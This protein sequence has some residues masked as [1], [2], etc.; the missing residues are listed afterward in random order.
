MDGLGEKKIGEGCLFTILMV[1]STSDQRKDLG[2]GQK[3][4]HSNEGKEA[5]HERKNVYVNGVGGGIL[6][7]SSCG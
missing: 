7:N 1:S 6:K 2:G 4:E 5:L 3:M